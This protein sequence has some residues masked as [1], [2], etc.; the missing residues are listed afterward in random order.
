[1]SLSS[2]SKTHLI[3]KTSIPEQHLGPPEINVHSGLLLDSPSPFP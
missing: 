3:N 2:Y 1:M